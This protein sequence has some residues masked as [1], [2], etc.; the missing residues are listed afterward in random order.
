MSRRFALLFATVLLA[1]AA[2]CSSDDD[3]GGNRPS[4][5]DVPS[6]AVAKV[7]D[8]EISEADLDRQVEAL[9]RA[10]RG[11]GSAASDGSAPGGA[12]SGDADGGPSAEE[13]LREQLEAQ[14]LAT[15][16]QRQAL[17]QE[18]KDRGI[19]VTDAE[20]RQ[21]WEA[22]SR[23]QFKTKKALRR[24]LGGQTE[25]DLLDQLRLQVLTERIHE[26]VSEEAGGGKQGAKA[27]ARFQ[28]EF[29][30]RWQDRTACREG[31]NAPGCTDDSK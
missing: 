9:A 10:Q 18:A 22:A 16:L 8:V 21:R 31:F 12:S 26:Q 1:L 3:N 4:S 5:E 25:Q 29:Q 19:E 2:G 23:G 6:G 28:K 20:V 30:Q 24:F 11:S 17:E 27:V 13:Q 15:L 7:G 14:A